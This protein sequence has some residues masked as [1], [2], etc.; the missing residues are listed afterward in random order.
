MSRKKSL[1]FFF[2]SHD[3]QHSEKT[4]KKKHNWVIEESAKVTVE[5][6]N[7]NAL[8]NFRSDDG[9]KSLS[10]AMFFRIGGDKRKLRR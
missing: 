1:C 9:P 4:Q 7:T 3:E 6:S 2:F 8:E 10:M 5:E